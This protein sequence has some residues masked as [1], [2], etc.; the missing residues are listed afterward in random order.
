MEH[1]PVEATVARQSAL[2]YL[3][4]TIGAALLFLLAAT[5]AGDSPLVARIGGTIWVGVLSLIVSMPLVTARVK[6]S[7]RASSHH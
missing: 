5:L 3:P 1:E 4:I 7:R 6:H 2:I